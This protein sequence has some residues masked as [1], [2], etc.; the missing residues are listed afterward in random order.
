MNQPH[1]DTLKV[2]RE[3]YNLRSKANQKLTF[4]GNFPDLSN[5]TDK[6]LGLGS[7][8]MMVKKIETLRRNKIE[9][10]SI[11]I[12]EKQG[13]AER[14]EILRRW[15]KDG[16]DVD[17]VNTWLN[18]TEEQS[19][20]AEV[21]YLRGGINYIKESRK[22]YRGSI[23]KYQKIIEKIIQLIEQVPDPPDCWIK[24]LDKDSLCLSIFSSQ[25]EKKNELKKWEKK[26][27]HLKS[28]KKDFKQMCKN[29]GKKYP[30]K[31][32]YG[33]EIVI[34]TNIPP[35]FIYN[36]LLEKV[37]SSAYGK[38]RTIPSKYLKDML[39]LLREIVPEDFPLGLSVDTFSERISYIRR[40]PIFLENFKNALPPT[41]SE[42][43]NQKSI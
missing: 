1:H 39:S 32:V 42:R 34:N 38:E 10:Q 12:Q 29:E 6:I 35:V 30:V 11:E 26:L 8:Q 16:I 21:P 28:L 40:N 4:K 5:Y 27:N 36:H 2:C 15:K 33:G 17:Y 14:T 18:F 24:V 41:L 37:G 31:P 13:K 43:L 3:I 7:P 22:H 25:K 19:P 9:H 20:H 23:E